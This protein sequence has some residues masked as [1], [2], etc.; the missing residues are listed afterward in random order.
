MAFSVQ[1]GK[2]LEADRLEQLAAQESQELARNRYLAE[3]WALRS[4]AFMN[5]GNTPAARDAWKKAWAYGWTKAGPTPGAPQRG[6]GETPQEEDFPLEIPKPF[7]PRPKTTW[8]RFAV[9]PFRST[10]NAAG[11]GLVHLPSLEDAATYPADT[12]HAEATFDFTPVSLSVGPSNWEVT[13]LEAIFGVDY[14]PLDFLQVGMKIVTAELRAR[15]NSALV[16]FENNNQIIPTGSRTPGVASI[17]LRGKVAW[18]DLFPGVS[19]GGLGEIKIPVADQENYLSSGTIDFALAGLLSAQFSEEWAAHVN[20]GFVMPFGDAGLFLDSGNT[21][22]LPATNDLA[23]V[24]SFAAGAIWRVLPRFSAGAQ[25]EYNS[26]PFQNVSVF[27]EPGTMF[28]L[29]GRGEMDHYAFFSFALGMGFG[30]VGADLYFSLA[31]DFTL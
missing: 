18:E 25:L 6:E 30:D 24:V 31:F 29:F 26:S 21:P 28:L 23:T 9:Q 20:L 22:G 16:L 4:E 8:E 19:L 1:D 2:R 7:K 13:R 5:E 14:A 27:D 17:L 12:W 3:A 10:R 15:G 11:H